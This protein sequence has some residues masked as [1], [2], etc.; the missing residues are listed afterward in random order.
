MSD[1][2]APSGTCEWC[3]N[4]VHRL[5]SDHIVPLEWYGDNDTSNLQWLCKP[6]HAMKSGWERRQQYNE[7]VHPDPYSPPRPEWNDEAKAECLARRRK[8]QEEKAHREAKRQQE[9][10]AIRAQEKRMARIYEVGERIWG[11]DWL[12]DQDSRTDREN[13]AMWDR[14]LDVVDFEEELD[15]LNEDA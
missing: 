9:Q 6:C 8:R 4:W 11:K 10:Q 12:E 1:R 5:D 2:G 3:G 7:Y 15:R 13:D 14:L